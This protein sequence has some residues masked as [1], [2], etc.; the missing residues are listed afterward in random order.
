MQAVLLK[1]YGGV[2]QLYIGTTEKPKIAADSVLVK[3]RAAGVNRADLGQRQGKYPPPPGTSSVLGLE[4]AGDVVEVGEAAGNKWNVGDKVMALISGGGYAEYA[5]VTASHLMKF[6]PHFSYEE[7]A[8][9]PEAFLTAYQAL[10][11]VAQLSTIKSPSILIHAAASGVGT[12]AI[13][14]CK[15]FGVN[16]IIATAGSQEKLD[17]CKQLGATTLINYKEGSFAPKVLEAT[18][19][20]GVSVLM[21]FIC[22]DYWNDNLKSLALEGVMTMQGT[23]S[24]VTAQNADLGPIL[25][26]RLK[27]MG[28]TLRSRDKEY[29]TRLI[30]DFDKLSAPLFANGTLKPIISKVFSLQEVAQAHQFVDDSK[31][32]GKVILKIDQ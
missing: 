32:I 26:K 27:I 6:P 19:N 3:V 13:Q 5:E 20:K 10:E 8:C 23:L 9:I 14:L 15:H 30:S 28:S 21:D 25:M 2:D 4:I 18:N 1:A 17:F 22:A 12:S 29:K 7:A 11:Y 31:N 16:P 24:G